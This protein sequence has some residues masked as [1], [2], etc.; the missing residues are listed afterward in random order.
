MT[1]LNWGKMVA[2]GM[3]LL[4]LCASVGYL[5]AGDMRRALYWLFAAC[6]T[7]TVTL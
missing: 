4:S 5:C 6:I 3:V 1:N 2:W 7:A